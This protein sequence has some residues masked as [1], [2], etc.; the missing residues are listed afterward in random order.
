MQFLPGFEDSYRGHRPLA[1]HDNSWHFRPGTTPAASRQFG[2]A[3]YVLEGL[4]T[5]RQGCGKPGFVA[6]QSSKNKNE[7]SHERH[8]L[9][10]SSIYLLCL[11]LRVYVF[12]HRSLVPL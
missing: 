3:G 8:I 4:Q 1:N 5:E 6:R 12:C 7:T 9:P 10:R 11:I 2:S